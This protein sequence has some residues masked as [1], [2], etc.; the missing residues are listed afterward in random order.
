MKAVNAV[1][2]ATFA[3]TPTAVAVLPMPATAAAPAPSFATVPTPSAALPTT[4]SAS[5]RAAGL[6]KTL[7]DCPC[8]ERVFMFCTARTL[9]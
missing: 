9:K 2:L 1:P 6:V 5:A 3:P 7:F 4:M 8:A